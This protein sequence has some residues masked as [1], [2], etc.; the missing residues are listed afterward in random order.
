MIE[1]AGHRLTEAIRPGG[2]FSRPA[3]PARR[4]TRP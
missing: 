2:G 3:H 4:A 1:G